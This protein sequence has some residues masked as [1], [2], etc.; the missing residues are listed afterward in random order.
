MRRAWPTSGGGYADNRRGG[1]TAGERAVSR[2]ELC[3][4]G[5]TETGMNRLLRMMCVV[6]KRAL[7]VGQCVAG[8]AVAMSLCLTADTP[9][10]VSS[11]L[12]QV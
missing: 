8:C 2:P 5:Q 10:A 6:T 7:H 11:Q 12:G 4:C 9:R 3:P 1:R